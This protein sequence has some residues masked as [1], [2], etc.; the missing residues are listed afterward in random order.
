MIC[1]I[2]QVF[3]APLY[4]FIPLALTIVANSAWKDGRYEECE[5]WNKITKIFLTIG[6]VYLAIFSI[7]VIGGFLYLFVAMVNS[8]F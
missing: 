3:F 5:K 8:G 7:V 6:F 1:S 4:G 2:I